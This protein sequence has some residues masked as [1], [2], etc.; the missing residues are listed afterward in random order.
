[1]STTDTAARLDKVQGIALATRSLAEG[2]ILNDGLTM[3]E[4]R[5]GIMRGLASTEALYAIEQA[6][7]A[8]AT[9]TQAEPVRRRRG[10]NKAKVA[11]ASAEV[12]ATM[13]VTEQDKCAAPF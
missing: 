13:N 5:E 7:V 12:A 3:L 6:P 9:P 4:I 1:M 11:E 2:A 8:A 10:P